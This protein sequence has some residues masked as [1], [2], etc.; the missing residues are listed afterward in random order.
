MTDV[1]FF[2]ADDQCPKFRLAQ[3]LR[4][5][6]AKHAALGFGADLALAGNDEHEGQ[7]IAMRAMQKA[8]QRPMGAWLRHAVKIEASL[9]LLF[10]LRELRTLAAAKRHKGW[11]R[12]LL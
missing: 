9:N 5:L 1:G 11:C 12:W 8:R 4:H 10:S 6:A 3:P 7:A 2:K